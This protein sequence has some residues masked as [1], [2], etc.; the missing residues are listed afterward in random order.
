[1]IVKLAS[2]FFFFVTPGVQFLI[3]EPKGAFLGGLAAVFLTEPS[4]W[5]LISLVVDFLR[6]ESFAFV[7]VAVVLE[8]SSFL[9]LLP[10]L[11]MMKGFVG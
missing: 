2:I 11:T 9:S 10:V 7:V 5:M 1:M 3:I 6:V 4:A 8:G